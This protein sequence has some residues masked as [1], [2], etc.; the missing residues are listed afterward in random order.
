MLHENQLNNFV[1]KLVSFDQNERKK[2][3]LKYLFKRERTCL[4]QH[5][6]R[7]FLFTFD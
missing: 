3:K 2:N 6:G 1:L 7:R 5:F 4:F